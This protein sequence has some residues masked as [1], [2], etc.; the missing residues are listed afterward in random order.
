MTQIFLCYSREDEVQVREIHRHLQELGF[1]PWMDK[2]ALLPGQRWNQ[3]ITRAIKASD[4]ILVFLSR[5]SVG[6]RG[7][8]QREFKLA[9]EVMEEIPEGV[10][11]TI[12]VCLD[13]CEIPAQFSQLQWC[14]LFEEDGFNKIV[15]AIRAGLLQRWRPEAEGVQIKFQE[16]RSDQHAAPQAKPRIRQSIRAQPSGPKA[17]SVLT[18]VRDT[19]RQ[20]IGERA[21]SVYEA[22]T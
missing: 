19:Y 6:K 21:F 3:E 2:A 7:Y 13:D 5:G 4:F 18:M 20:H 10:I 15:R 9:L 11:H 22:L 8:V 17:L 14:K 1:N 16:E 12:P